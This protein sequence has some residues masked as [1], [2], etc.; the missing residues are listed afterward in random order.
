MVGLS[1]R[2]KL[3]LSLEARV[4]LKARKWRPHL[5][6][7]QCGIVGAG[8]KALFTMESLFPMEVN[9]RFSCCKDA[10]EQICF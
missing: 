2:A 6:H 8:E 7:T 3:L 1:Q 9:L 4:G 10:G 5:G